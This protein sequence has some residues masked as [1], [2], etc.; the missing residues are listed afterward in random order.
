[1]QKIKNFIHAYRWII[2]SIGLLV[3]LLMLAVI[4]GRLFT[5]MAAEK[6]YP[7]LAQP[8]ETEAPSTFTT[9]PS[10]A[11]TE[12]I[13]G[14]QGTGL[15][16]SIPTMMEKIAFKREK[17]G[18]N[19]SLR[20]RQACVMH[21]LCYRHGYATYGYSQADCD[22]QL[23]RSAYR[24]CRQIHGQSSDKPLNPL[25]M[26]TAC[27]HEAKEV[28]LGVTLGG[29]G[30]FHS[31]RSSTFFEYDPQPSMADNYVV[32]R[33]VP[34]GIVTDPGNDLGIRSFYF[35]RN[36][37]K[38]RVLSAKPGTAS[39]SAVPF[40]NA[41]VATPPV[42][43]GAAESN[44]RLPLPP[45]ISLA[46][47]S[48]SETSV[49][50]IPFEITSQNSAGKTRYTLALTPCMA[51]GRYV[52]ERDAD[53][54]VNKFS[55][56]E[57]K[58][59]LLALTHRGVLSSNKTSVEIEQKSFLKN[60]AGSE[61]AMPDY[62]LNGPLT[63]VHNQY[64]F[65]P[66]DMLLE[67]DFSNK[68]T[69]AWTFA[70]GVQVSPGG[71]Q[72]IRDNSGKDYSIRVAVARQ[73]L[74]NNPANAIQRFSLSARE[75]DEPLSLIRLGKKEG[76][77][78]VGLAWSAE[79]LKRVEGGHP[80]ENPPLIKI[81][82]VPLNGSAPDPTPQALSVPVPLPNGYI[83][84]PPIVA[85]LST[86]DPAL[87]VLTR[88]GP[89]IWQSEKGQETNLATSKT[90]A[91]DFIIT[92]L[93]SQVGK[94]IYFANNY[95]LRCEIGLDKQ[96]Q[97]PDASSIKQR[98]YRT[99]YGRYNQTLEAKNP[100]DQ[101]NHIKSDLAQRWRMS[102]VI[103]SE[104]KLEKEGAVMALSMVFNGFPA[105]SFQLLLKSDNGRLR[106]IHSDAE[107]R[108]INFCYLKALQGNL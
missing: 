34:E 79:D 92:S 86:Q 91:V 2:I 17:D 94:P 78:L 29:A 31:R 36:T 16:C 11:A 21:D 63:A 103:V 74:G 22:T 49:H 67:R 66:H 81:W 102:Q 62:A 100:A 13:I 45:L 15:N 12:A 68:V 64:R 98:A 46:R 23:Q 83:S 93:I 19:I 82:R 40:P 37:V 8:E 57:N 6:V 26:Y 70:R 42:L 25:S 48:F 107:P 53:A 108:F 69:H 58:P 61:D 90:L 84:V 101:I 30:S 51:T 20:F 77:A 5:G 52:C 47:N 44:G 43:T 104:R 95:Q 96:L 59:F 18:S 7:V 99:I 38:M 60:N 14:G 105:M 88:V 106:Y 1:M 87:M 39:A 27:E 75:T 9:Y 10:S 89:D 50:L 73:P 72:F 97:S 24:L 3:I 76:T 65:L 28:L 71:K 33:A 56:I 55:I 41:L 80:A 54:S 4:A 32:G 35:W 85:R